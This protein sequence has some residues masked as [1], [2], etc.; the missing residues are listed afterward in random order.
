M[1]RITG[2]QRAARMRNI[3]IAR[4]AKKKAR[5]ALVKAVSRRQ[6]KAAIHGGH[7]SKY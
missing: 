6:R 2:R 1:A 3:V 7:Y 4:K 5:A